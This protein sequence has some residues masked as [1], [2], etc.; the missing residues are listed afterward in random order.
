[1][2]KKHPTYEKYEANEDGEIRLS[3]SL[4]KQTKVKHGYFICRINGRNMYSHRFIW[5]CFN[6]ILRKGEVID[7]LNTIRTDN[8]ISN[9][10]KCDYTENM[11]NE[12]T[13]LHLREAKA[14]QCGKKVLKLDKHTNEII[15]WY[16]S[17]SE[18]A[19]A[20]KI[21][22][23]NYIRYVCEGRKGYYTAGGFKWKYTDECYVCK[24]GKWCVTECEYDDETCKL[25]FEPS[26]TYEKYT[27]ITLWKCPGS[28]SKIANTIIVPGDT[29]SDVII[30]LKS[31]LE[32][33]NDNNT[34]KKIRYA[35]RHQDRWDM[36]GNVAFA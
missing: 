13:R 16:P 29:K 6:G 23:K 1:M 17:I 11:S 21:S 36:C 19:R 32:C 24:W 10:K 8:R 28:K 20:N 31:M 9:L 33:C 25:D 7:H 12:L 14:K 27:N 35:L 34:I 30:R 18:A 2:W 22:T 5:E 15:D 4:L 26:E 3:T